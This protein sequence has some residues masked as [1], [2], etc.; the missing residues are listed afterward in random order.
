MGASSQM[1]LDFFLEDTTAA[2][3]SP[4]LPE[5]SASV[6]D[7]GPSMFGE[8]PAA[9]DT[10][11]KVDR[12]LAAIGALIS[13][14][15]PLAVAYSGGKDSSV[16]VA[17]VLEA[18]RQARARGECTAPILITHARTGIDNPA[19]DLV[20]QAE[21]ARIRAYARREGLPVRV[22]IAEPALND[23]WAVRILSGRALPTFA[24]SSSRDCAISWKL[25][26]QQRQRK[27]AFKELREAGEPVVLVGTRFDESSGRAE[28]MAERRETDTTVWTTEVRNGD[29]KLVRLEQRLSPIAH[30]NQE[31]IWV[32]LSELGS[33]ERQ[34]YTDAKDLWDVYRDGG[35]SSCV[36]VADDAMKA[37]SKACGARFGCALC[38]A[39]GRD[40]SLESMLESDE[41]Y[42]FLRPL[43]RIQRFLVDTQYD[44]SRRSWL[45]RTVS[46]DGY[47]AIAPDAYSPAMQRELLLY[48]MTAD[49]D[50][51]QAARALGLAPRFRLVS[52]EQLIAID[53]IWSIQGYHP[54]PFEAIHLWEQVYVRGKSFVPPEIDSSRFDKKMP[55][56]RWLFV[57][58][59]DS[60]ADSG[61]ELMYSGARNLLAD[62]SGA[63]ESHGCAPNVAL[64][65]GRVVMAMESS[66]ML[67]VDEEGA[68]LFMAFEVMDSRI[69][70]RCAGQDP[71]EAFSH[72]QML[73]TIAT[74]KRHLGLIDDMLRRAAWKRRHGLFAMDTTELLRRSVSEAERKAGVRAPEGQATVGEEAQRALDAAHARRRATAW[75][76]AHADRK[77]LVA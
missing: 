57:D 36:V 26:P 60:D 68:E 55:R 41:K 20:A 35:N 74:S 15:I 1:T 34:S 3:E 67:S 27:A 9:L 72:Y 49:R 52:L 23:S 22:D 39:V 77:A 11:A 10:D 40:K 30:W 48:A 13:R 38:T 25:V 44:L 75:K 56:P 65:D 4:G 17:L 2:V 70:E 73:G 28:R 24:N 63:T 62:F 54:R 66:P 7:A 37:S 45:G 32:F 14:G 43:N 69:H 5:Q 50:E 58:R 18:A 59:W 64:A 76:P 8:D 19:M 46:D 31:D 71:S 51:A 53:A 42:R 12:A 6:C 61:F 29:G 16:M 33:G 47:V 21:I